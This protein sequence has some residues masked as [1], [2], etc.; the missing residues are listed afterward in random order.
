MWQDSFVKCFTLDEL[1]RLGLVSIQA[2]KRKAYFLANGK[3]RL[4]IFGGF[5]EEP[6]QLS[7]EQAMQQT[8]ED[9]FLPANCIEAY[10]DDEVKGGVWELVFVEVTSQTLDSYFDLY[11]ETM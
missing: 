2:Q 6:S 7:A 4:T 11:S 8:V 5:E 3:K 10:V 1:D 9:G